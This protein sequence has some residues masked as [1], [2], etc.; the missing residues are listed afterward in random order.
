[1]RGNNMNYY[2]NKI[3]PSM[4]EKKRMSVDL[5]V[6]TLGR[7][8]TFS[9]YASVFNIID[10]HHDI[11]RKGAFKTTLAKGPAHVKLLWQHKQD[12]PIGTFHTMFED[13][14]GLYVEGKLLLDVRRAKEAYTFLK[15][16]IV[17]GL[18]IG[19]SPIHYQIDS[20]SGA[21][22]LTE[23]ELWEVSL[24]TFPANEAAGVT[25]VK[26]MDEYVTPTDMIELCD[27]V[28][29]ASQILTKS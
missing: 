11:I 29:F 1:M 10:N 17:K 23:I 3:S 7:D 2:D 18:S 26:S 13:E 4:L 8:G 9:G 19:Y 21:R 22:E 20:K 5:E 27:A 6:K 25:V 16:G 14:M 12:E 15:Q 28:D 24:V